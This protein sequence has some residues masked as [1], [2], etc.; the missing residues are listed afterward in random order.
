LQRKPAVSAWNGNDRG[1][2]RAS[3]H[4]GLAPKISA[5]NREI[6]QDVHVRS[7]KRGMKWNGAIGPSHKFDEPA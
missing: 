7:E 6:G 4:D 1:R 5:W 2:A 3:R